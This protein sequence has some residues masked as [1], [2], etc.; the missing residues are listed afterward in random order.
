M[1]AAVPKFMMDVGVGTFFG[2]CKVLWVFHAVM[3]GTVF[4]V[5]GIDGLLSGYWLSTLSILLGAVFFATLIPRFS[6]RLGPLEKGVALCVVVI[7]SGQVVANAD[8]A[9]QTALLQWLI[10]VGVAVLTTQVIKQLKARGI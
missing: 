10:V 4:M 2:F 5:I 1:I 8:E 6:E 3:G 9:H 7:V